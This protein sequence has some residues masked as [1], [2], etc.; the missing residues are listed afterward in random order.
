MK[1]H[2]RGEG[3]FEKKNIHKKVMVLFTVSYNIYGWHTC[4]FI[5]KTFF[6]DSILLQN[7]HAFIIGLYD[8]VAYKPIARQ[9]PQ[10]QT[11]QQPLLCNGAVNAPTTIELL[12]ETVLCNLLLGNCN[13]WTTTMSVRPTI[14]TFQLENHWSDIHEIFY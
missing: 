13:S 14:Y 3:C 8:I 11:R 5:S 4:Q 9:R 7:H 6:H 12:L 2:R 10:K 1:V